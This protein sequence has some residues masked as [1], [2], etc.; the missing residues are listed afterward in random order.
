MM[1]IMRNKFP[2]IA[3]VALLFTASF[4]V[5]GRSEEVELPAKDKFHLFLLVGQSNMAGRGKV[6]PD[7]QQENPKVLMLN[8]QGKWV[9]AVDPLHF[10]KP[11]VVGVGLGRTF[12]MEVSQSNPDITI[13]LIPCAVGGSPIESWEPGAWDAPTKSHPYDDAMK[14][15][16]EALKSGQLAG[17]L[18]HQGESDSRP[19]RAKVYEQKLRELIARFRKELGG[20]DVPFIIGQLGQFEENPWNEAKAK[21]DQAHKN[22]AKSDKKV[23]F[24]ESDGLTHKGDKVHFNA[25]SYREFGKR[26][27][28][29]YSEVTEKETKE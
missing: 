1:L 27:A 28:K 12:G 22:I 24:V 4:V 17:I 8:Q 25:E 26:Y 19:E 13:G 10:D 2:L 9:P 7:D 21:V 3:L 15:A 14:R 6:T 20:N 18:W 5:T 29:A 23:E 16:N 11:R